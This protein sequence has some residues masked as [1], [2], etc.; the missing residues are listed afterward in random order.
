MSLHTHLTYEWVMS[1]TWMSHVTHTQYTVLARQ[2][3]MFILDFDFTTHW[4]VGWY[5]YIWYSLALLHT[6]RWNSRPSASDLHSLSWLYYTL[7]G[8]IIQ[9]CL[10]EVYATTHPVKGILQVSV[11]FPFLILT[12][13][14]YIL[15]GRIIQLCTERSSTL[16]HTQ[17]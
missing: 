10:T 12:W 7:R 9:L 15:R 2:P 3:R 13:L 11:R 6:Q 5:N 8:R 16:L 1:H 17:W 4:E 14:Y